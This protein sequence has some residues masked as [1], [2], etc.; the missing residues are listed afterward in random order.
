MKRLV[1]VGAGHAH[2]QVLRHWIDR[3]LAGVDLVVVSP[4][5]LAPYS[6]MVPGWIAGTY[7]FDDLCINFRALAAAAGA[8]FVQSELECLAPRDRRLSLTSGANLPYDLLSLNV[9]ATLTPPMP[10]A[11]TILPLRPL[12]LLRERWDEVMERWRGS[13]STRPFSVTAV[14]GGAAGVESLLAVLSRLRIERPDRVVRGTL[15]TRSQTL[16]PRLAPAAVR[17]A[18]RA[19]QRAGV[20]V[21]HGAT[22]EDTIDAG[23][24]LVLWAT[25]AEPHHWQRDAKRR[26]GLAATAQG[27]IR[28]DTL[29]RSVSH[30]EV[31]AAGD[32]AEWVD[33]LPKAGVY[34]VRMGQALDRNLRS[35]LGH[36]TAAPYR[37]QNRVLALLDI[38]DGRAIASRGSVG[39]EG[40]WVRKWKDHIDRRFLR[41]F[42]S[43][44]QSTLSAAAVSP[45]FDPPS[46]GA[47]Q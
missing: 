20:T 7:D 16:L 28:V 27:Y 43:A 12:S 21:R 34:A 1:L 42:A 6:G 47:P 18:Q 39:F 31:Y 11:G 30:S 5:A 14:G 2:A 45:K 17:A 41:R 13:R 35:V 29:L 4:I 10:D 46:A 19:L 22:W 3:P 8:S 44:A 38:G 33:P 15:V 37:P 23:N 40:G 36:G 26:G 32:C 25:G 9:G 24:D